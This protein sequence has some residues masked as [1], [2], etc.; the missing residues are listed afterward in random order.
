MKL[1]ALMLTTALSFAGFAFAADAPKLDRDTEKFF[2]E[3]AIGGIAEVEAGKLAAQKGSSADVKQF[4]EMMVKD[5]SGANAKLKDLA[6]KKNV[7]LPAE[8]DDKHKRAAENLAKKQGA[9]FDKAYADQMVKDH[10]KTIDLFEGE[11]KRGKDADVKAF[12]EATLPTLR[13][14]LKAAQQLE[15]KTK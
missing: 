5:H 12:A 13:E 8:L 2:K 15:E 11:A 6:A 4:G 1:I 3:A 7:T 10:K 9:D 14:H